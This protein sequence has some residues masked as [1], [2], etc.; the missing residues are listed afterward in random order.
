MWTGIVLLGMIGY[1]VNLLFVLAERRML[2]WHRGW[3]ATARETG[4][5]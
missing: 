2:R 4:G 5:G 3:R 1:G